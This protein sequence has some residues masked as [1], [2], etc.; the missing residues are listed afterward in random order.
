MVYV[1]LRMT[2]ASR[3]VYSIMVEN[4]GVEVTVQ[5]QR[6]GHSAVKTRKEGVSSEI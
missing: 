3:T 4:E 2:D 5:L 1:L 6:S